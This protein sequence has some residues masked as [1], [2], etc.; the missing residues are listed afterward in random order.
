[1][2]AKVVARQRIVAWLSVGYRETAPPMPVRPSGV[3][4]SSTLVPLRACSPRTLATASVSLAMSRAGL[5]E[6]AALRDQKLATL[7][8]VRQI[9]STIVMK[10]VVDNRPL[11]LAQP[12]QPRA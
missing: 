9:T 12:G 2:A 5:D 8:G 6:Y 7:P 1:V 4:T 10:T 11:P 3:A